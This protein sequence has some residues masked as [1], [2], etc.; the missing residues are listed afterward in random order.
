[1]ATTNTRQVSAV[2][3]LHRRRISRATR[4]IAV[5]AVAATGI[6]AV[7]AAQS[8][9]HASAGTSGGTTGSVDDQGAVEP[10]DDGT[11]FRTLTPSQSSPSQSFG[12]PVAR[13]GGS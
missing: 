11:G 3:R 12:P 6:F 8:T 1:M 10:G 2:R 7:A 5:L 4:A 13:S 9:R